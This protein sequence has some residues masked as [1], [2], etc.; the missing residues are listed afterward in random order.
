M[1]S[2]ALVSCS[3][4]PELSEILPRLEELIEASYGVND[5]LFGDGPDTYERVYDPSVNVKFYD[6]ADGTKGRYRYIE[7][8]TLGTVL[9]YST[10]TYGKEYSYLHVTNVPNTT[11][12]CVYVDEAQGLYYVKIEYTEKEYEFYYTDSFPEDYDV[13]VMNQDNPYQSIESIKTYAQTVYSREYLE[14]IYGPIFDGAM[15]SQSSD[16]GYI[17]ARY[18][19]YTDEGGESWFLFSNTYEPLTTEKRI[20]DLTTAK[21][22]RRSNKEYV[23][24]EV[25]SYLESAP[26]NKLKVT[27]SLIIQDG[28]WMLDT[29]TY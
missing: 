25:E 12:D 22:V 17:K 29:P 6:E 28:V 9:A 24:I 23:N 8:E 4:P 14:S 2:S 13:V 15:I 26:E 5:L 21:M 11:E 3:R 7:D 18:S 16:N 19:E 20:F 10:K 1:L 27:L